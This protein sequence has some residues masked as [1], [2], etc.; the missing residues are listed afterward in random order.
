MPLLKQEKTLCTVC[1]Y[2]LPQTNF[3]NDKDNQ[4]SQLFWGRAVIENATAFYFFSKGSRYQKIMHKLK[5]KGQKEIGIEMGIHFATILTGTDF[6]G[7]DAIV[8]IPLHPD[9]LKT[10]GYNQSEMIASGMG[11]VF[12]KPLYRDVLVRTKASATQTKKSRIERWENVAS[13][14]MAKNENKIKNKHILL[15][16]DVVTT[17]ATLEACA[18]KI[19]E[20][21]NTKVSIATLAVAGQ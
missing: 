10:R 16:D 1:W 5:Y 12:Q 11:R 7:I 9:K 17:G 21:E 4:V 3:H 14:F 19:L 6:A 8:P 13:I 18:N 15:V 20:I 2:H